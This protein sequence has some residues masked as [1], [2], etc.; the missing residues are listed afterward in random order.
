MKVSELFPIPVE[1]G[2]AAVHVAV[3]HIESTIRADGNVGRLVEMRNVPRSDARL[4]QREKK[5]AVVR[6][7]EH[8]L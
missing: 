3:G 7:L 5:F 4:S 8:L 1:D 2:D 6:E